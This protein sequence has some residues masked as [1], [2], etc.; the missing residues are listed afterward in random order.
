M[1]RFTTDLNL[2]NYGQT[3]IV[4]SR[5]GYALSTASLRES[6]EGV[7]CTCCHARSLV[8]VFATGTGRD[9]AGS[10]GV[11]VETGLCGKAQGPFPWSCHEVRSAACRS[12]QYT[13]NVVQ[14]TYVH[15]SFPTC[16]KIPALAF[17][18]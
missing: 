8:P 7:I 10:L 9:D 2:V 5:R 16:T 6:H 1:K 13:D 18:P 15:L 12:S 17:T 11:R 3:A 4:S 14:L